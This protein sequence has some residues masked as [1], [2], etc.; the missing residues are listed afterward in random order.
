MRFLVRN[1][2]D[3][4]IVIAEN[5]ERQEEIR[6]LL[7][8]GMQT[9]LYGTLAIGLLA[10]AW[11]ARRGQNRLDLIGEGL[12]QVARGRLD[13]RIALPGRVDDLTLLADRINATT[14]R[15]ELAMDQMR[16]QSSN[17]AH[18]LRTPLARLRAQLETNLNDLTE[19]DSPVS[20][21]DLDAALAQIDH[22]SRNVRRFAATGPYR[23]WGRT[24]C[25][26]AG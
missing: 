3:G 11:L 4:R 20:A 15:L 18:D 14:G 9:A 12:A 24:G 1:T 25:L 22:L 17:I 26:C 8:G 23:K 5:V 10:G 2:S 16:I 19:K 21:D 7:V 13:V 6:E